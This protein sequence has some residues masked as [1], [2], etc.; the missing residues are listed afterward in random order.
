MTQ[1]PEVLRCPTKDRPQDNKERLD[2]SYGV[3]VDIW[4]TG[5]LAYE[6][7]NGVP[8][9]TR[10]ERELTERLIL[11][12]GLHSF[13]LPVSEDCRDFVSNCLVGDGCLRPS[14]TFC[15]KHPWITGL[16]KPLKTRGTQSNRPRRETCTDGFGDLDF[17]MHNEMTENPCY[18]RGSQLKKRQE[19]SSLMGEIEELHQP[20]QTRSP[21]PIQLINSPDPLSKAKIPDKEWKS[22]VLAAAT[23]ET[24]Q[25]RS[26][27][28]SIQRFMAEG[29]R[30]SANS[31]TL[32]RS[33]IQMSNE[34][35]DDELEVP[36]I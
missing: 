21:S 18:E 13:L 31:P 12:G 25:A 14:A 26:N 30:S 29:F 4:S 28:T 5:I 7:V 3:G 2:L 24:D 36:D 11:S 35:F 19:S 16:S 15:L 9:F 20:P 8:P 27:S 17:Q 1:A 23:K 32:I 33:Q 6:L 34:D 22:K 10:H